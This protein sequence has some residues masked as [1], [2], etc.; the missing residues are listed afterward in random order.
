M[1][2]YVYISRCIFLFDI[3]CSIYIPNINSG[4]IMLLICVLLIF[5]VSEAK[6]ISII[7]RLTSYICINI[8]IVNSYMFFLIIS[9][10]YL[11]S[12]LPQDMFLSTGRVSLVYKYIILVSD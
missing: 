6:N 1:G 7:S 11:G 2:S 8:N 4:F 3:V 10:V 12:Q 5:H 9:D